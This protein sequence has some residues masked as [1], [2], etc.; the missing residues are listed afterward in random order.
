MLLS[1]R[2]YAT[3]RGCAISSV[4]KAI[5]TGRITLV[6]GK[7]D[8]DKADQEWEKNTNPAY[9]PEKSAE[10]TRPKFS[11]ADA[12]A[13]SVALD[14]ALK[15]MDLN[16]RQGKTLDADTVHSQMHI[17]ARAARDRVLS[18]PRKIA[19]KL[20]H[21]SDAKE[22]EQILEKA[23]EKELYGLSDFLDGGNRS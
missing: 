11:L 14:V 3:H 18:V 2:D 17:G 1:R 4:Q 7:I 5:E 9:N 21:K 19:A 12:R 20:V 13:Q 10:S 22:I 16:E 15:K 6:N 23:L 8:P